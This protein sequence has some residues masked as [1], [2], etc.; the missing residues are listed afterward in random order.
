MNTKSPAFKLGQQLGLIAYGFN[1]SGYAMASG[2]VEA[3]NNNSNPNYGAFQKVLCKYASEA[4]KEAGEMGS[5]EYSLYKEAAEADGWYPELDKFSDAVLYALGNVIK[6][7]KEERH[8]NTRE[9][10]V[11]KSS[12]ALRS[13]IPSMAQGVM[14]NTP[15]LLKSVATLGVG[16]GAIAGSL[17]WLMNRHVAQDE[18]TAEGMKAKIRYYKKLTGDIRN[19]LGAVPSTVDDVREAV[20]DVI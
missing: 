12:M 3:F 1:K 8:F 6:E 16:G 19:Q 5:F 14:N 10:I 15:D 7:A 2:M 4:F 20:H 13:M 11:K 18:D 9:A 17:A